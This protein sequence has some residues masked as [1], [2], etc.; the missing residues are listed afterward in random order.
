MAAPLLSGHVDEC[1]SAP[2]LCSAGGCTNAV[3]SYVCTCP[4]GLPAAWTAP[5]AWGSWGLKALEGQR[6]G[7]RQAPGSSVFATPPLAWGLL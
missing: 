1:L 6:A 2:G 7:R 4:R 3:G 5:A